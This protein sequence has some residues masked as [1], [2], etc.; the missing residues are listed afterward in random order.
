M[1]PVIPKWEEDGLQVAVRSNNETGYMFGINYSRYHPKKVQ[2]SVKFEVKLKD[3]TLR[4]PQKGIEMQDSTVFIWPLNVELGAMRLNY[5]TAQLMG[6]VDNCYLFFQNRQIPVELSF[7]K[8]T[9]K[10]VEVNRAKIKEESDSWVVS[11]LNPGKDCVLKVQLQNG[12]EK[13]VVILTEKRLITV[14]YWNKMGRKYA[15]F[16]MRIYT[17]HLEMFIFSLL[18]RRLLIIS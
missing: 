9:V 6:S 17:V 14:G 15:I 3:K 11:G 10:E 13:Y 5:A 18:I 7:D 2:K 1:M 8:S 16:L 4:F 12:E